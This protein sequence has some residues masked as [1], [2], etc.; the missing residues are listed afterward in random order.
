MDIINSGIDRARHKFWLYGSVTLALI[1]GLT[2]L[3]GANRV[4]AHEGL[5]NNVGD[6]G[7]MVQAYDTERDEHVVHVHSSS[8]MTWEVYFGSS[9]KIDCATR[10]SGW[11]EASK[12]SRSSDI[13]TESD[14]LT[15]TLESGDNN[16]GVCI[17]YTD[18]DVDHDDFTASGVDSD[19][20]YADTDSDTEGAQNLVVDLRGPALSIDSAEANMM[21]VE[22]DGLRE[23]SGPLQAE[24][25]SALDVSAMRVR[26]AFLDSAAC[27]ATTLTADTRYSKGTSLIPDSGD[28]ALPDVAVTK[29]QAKSGLTFEIKTAWANNGKHLCVEVTDQVGNAGYKGEMVDVDFPLTLTQVPSTKTGE[30]GT[31][32]VSISSSE[33]G[34]NFSYSSTVG[35][36]Q[37]A[38]GNC[39]DSPSSF[40]FRSSVP[41]GGYKYGTNTF[42]IC[43]VARDS[44]KNEIRV[45]F[46]IDDADPV[47][48]VVLQSNQIVYAIGSDAKSELEAADAGVDV[49]RS[50]KGQ[51]RW[52]SRYVDALA[53][54]GED[55]DPEAAL[56]AA[57]NSENFKGD[58]DT[59]ATYT[60]G[61][62]NSRIDLSKNSA[63]KDRYDAVCFRIRDVADKEA[64]EGVLLKDF[65]VS[66]VIDGSREESSPRLQLSIT[67]VEGTVAWSWSD[68]ELA[69]DCSTDNAD[70]FSFSEPSSDPTITVEDDVTAYCVRATI[71]TDNY[72]GLVVGVSE[73]EA[74]DAAGPE[75]TIGDI[76]NDR[77]SASADD[78]AGS[79]VDA[80]TWQYTIL[81]NED[82]ARDNCNDDPLQVI[83]SGDWMEGKAFDV[84]A[85]H[86]NKYACFRVSDNVGNYGYASVALPTV[87]DNTPPTLAVTQLGNILDWKDEDAGG[88][89]TY[90]YQMF[91]TAP[92]DCMTDSGWMDGM[93]ATLAESDNGMHYCFR[94]MDHG[95]NPAYSGPL[96][97]SG[98]DTTSP[99][100]TVSQ[101]GNTVSAVSGESGTDGWQHIRSDDDPGEC[102]LLTGWTDIKQVETGRRIT[103]LTVADSGK[104]ICFQVVDA[105]GNPGHKKFQI[106]TI[107][108]EDET[109]RT[110]S[111]GSLQF[112]LDGRRLTVSLNPV[113]GE[114]E[115]PKVISWNYLFFGSEAG[116]RNNCTAEK[117]QFAAVAPGIRNSFNVRTRD[118]RGPRYVHL[119]KW[120]CFRA[121]DEDNE[122]A[123]G[124]FPVPAQLSDG[125]TPDPGDGTTPD[126]GDGTTPDPGD[127]TTPDPGDGTTPD[128]G[129]DGQQPGQPGGG[130]DGT[131]PDPGD[132]GTTPDPGDDGTTPDPG[133]DG[134]TPDPVEEGG[135][136]SNY[137]WYIIGAVVVVI[138]IVVFVAM[139]SKGNQ[140]E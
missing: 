94:V 60:T 135:F 7:N 136:L 106:E 98:V 71:G 103:G 83:A 88:I 30:E 11:K 35:N 61:T 31:G 81:A 130:D 76:A 120:F 34:V 79:G 131:T 65:E 67:G 5:G 113:E 137:L 21:E 72:Y 4:S 82:S 10:K 59:Y 8:V 116:A 32:R 119:G 41:D 87:E 36:Y 6:G 102:K 14:Q 77:V 74:L 90:E 80:D 129:D 33:S 43:A 126:P 140:R 16:L 100:I 20:D 125:T 58:D 39:T 50:N 107:T 134:V 57:C 104:W 53:F 78:G 93:K 132:D 42:A 96:T 12:S 95:D 44:K 62:R 15:L 86:S 24:D 17:R 109:T 138:L 127:G 118:A 89:A 38:S 124:V 66:P 1:A 18:D 75:V 2:L 54:D 139:G 68:A 29:A 108:V 115:A 13:V 99:T 64:Y 84:V 73:G 70:G 37:V 22:V 92:A 27:D 9:T 133:D 101:S 91:D 3:V 47:I 105:A 52:D 40:V 85:S 110:A 117:N 121:I 114:T 25:V 55:P 49:V 26:Y 123:F 111:D 112:N 56:N 97:I 48:S 46:I 128:P 23:D 122:E 63:Y 45:A 69:D 28:G 51:T 19:W